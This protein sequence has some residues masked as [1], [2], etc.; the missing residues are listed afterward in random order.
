MNILQVDTQIGPQKDFAHIAV[1]LS[2]QPESITDQ[3]IDCLL[4]MVTHDFNQKSWNKA[5][6]FDIFI[7]PDTRRRGSSKRY[8]TPMCTAVL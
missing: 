3:W 2:D 1:S 5:E 7:Q 8:S 6:E 4:R